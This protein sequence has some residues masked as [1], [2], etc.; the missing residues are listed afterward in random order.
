MDSRPNINAAA[1]RNIRWSAG[2]DATLRK[3]YPDYRALREHLPQRTIAALKNRIRAIG[4]A[5][6]RHIWTNLEVA[7]LRKAYVDGMRGS[8]LMALFPGL[9]L[10]Q[11]EKKARHIRADRREPSRAY[12][13]EPA[14]DAIRNRS[15]E[16]RISLV[17]LDRLA[18]T[19]RYFQSSSRRAFL[20]PIVRAARIMDAEV[21][22]EWLDEI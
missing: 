19:G 11:I 4:I 5:R 9:Q 21:R 15:K 1:T 10:S 6:R 7:R 13:G 20:K 8:D 12:F 17:E 16:M 2:E 22:I 14:L 3:L 18:R